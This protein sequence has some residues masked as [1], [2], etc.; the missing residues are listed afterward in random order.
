MTSGKSKIPYLWKGITDTKPQSCEVKLVVL[1]E[2]QAHFTAN[3]LA[4]KP[5]HLEICYKMLLVQINLGRPSRGWYHNKGMK[6]WGHYPRRYLIV[7]SISV[8][9]SRVPQW[10]RTLSTQSRTNDETPAIYI[11]FLEHRAASVIIVM[12]NPGTS[13]RFH[14]TDTQ[15]AMLVDSCQWKP[16][17]H[18]IYTK[19][20]THT[21]NMNALIPG[22]ILS[23]E[24]VLGSIRHLNSCV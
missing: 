14:F 12:S 22:I 15:Y 16:K 18:T 13:P 20:P 6:L 1:L 11:I 7:L 24:T 3:I 19:K 9:K 23:Y 4:W 8:L 21:D 2:V 5:V 17:S 10:D